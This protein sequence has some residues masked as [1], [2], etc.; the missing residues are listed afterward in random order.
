VKGG[1]GG[2]GAVRGSA[3]RR[4]DRSR[5]WEEPDPPSPSTPTSSTS[6]MSRCRRLRLPPR[7]RAV[8]PHFTDACTTARGHQGEDDH[9]PALVDAPAFEPRGNVSSLRAAAPPLVMPAIVPGWVESF[10]GAAA[11]V[12]ARTHSDLAYPSRRRTPRRAARVR[13][14]A[15][16]CSRSRS[17]SCV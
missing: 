7:R 8:P 16:C 4:E 11:F 14:A 1:E 17:R 9:F 6:S 13:D 15:L 5:P 12:I 2:V 10:A 3:V